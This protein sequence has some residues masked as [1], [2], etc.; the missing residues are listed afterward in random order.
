M[1]QSIK[2]DP[3]YPD[4]SII[5]QAVKVLRDGGLVVFPTETVYGIGAKADDETAIRRLCQLKERDPQKPFTFH[6]A[7]K[8]ELKMYGCRLCPLSEEIIHKLWPGPVTFIF[9][10]D[11]GSKGF[12][13]P[14]D[15]IAC[16]LIRE[17]GF[18][19]VAPSA[20]LKGQRS[21]T[22]PEE[23]SIEIRKDVDFIIEAGPTRYRRE[24][25]ILDFTS[26]SYKIIREGAIS[27]Q[28]LKDIELAFWKR[29][30]KD[31]RTLVFI[32]TGNSCRSVMA[33]GYLKMRL[34]QIGR[35]DIEVISFGISPM[36]G[37]SATNEAKE[38]M[39]RFGIDITS[40]KTR[41]VDMRKIQQ[42]DL[43]F[44][45]EEFHRLQLV[46]MLPSK[47]CQIFLL[48]EFGF[49]GGKDTNE[50]LEIPDPIGRPI[51]VYEDC[52]RLL[53]ASIDRMLEVLL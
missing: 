18:P 39:A 43:I 17:A 47:W 3:N 52:F 38:V 30:G 21:P 5:E 11:S 13:Y 15:K 35:V 49:L 23:I 45:M 33:E 29:I 26:L 19:I 41:A 32:C 22:A 8:D 2:I 50:I 24:S 37:A 20:N 4:S 51:S 14:D 28:V 12:R 25:T 42:A 46:N 44:V 34:R 31:I 36:P 9:A 40:H 27:K 53:K 7:T 16:Q 10:T 1:P 48:A 6:I